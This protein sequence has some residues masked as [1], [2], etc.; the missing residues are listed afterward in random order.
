MSM[1]ERTRHQRKGESK[2]HSVHH[3]YEGKKMAA[4]VNHV[5]Y[6]RHHGFESARRGD[7]VP[8]LKAM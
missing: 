6:E 2:A 3:K 4:V 7:S 5:D 1:S 8:P